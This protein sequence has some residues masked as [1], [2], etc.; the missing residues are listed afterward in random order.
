FRTQDTLRLEVAL[1]GGRERYAWLD[2]RKF[3]DRELRDLVGRGMTGTGNFALHTQH[4]F[5]PGIA[6]FHRRGAASHQGRSAL[7]YDYEVPWEN[8]AYRISNPPHEEVVAFRGSFLVDAETLDLLR[9]EVLAAEI[10]PELGF[11]R[12]SSVLEYA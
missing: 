7:R 5:E 2:A 4:V 10:P 9:L 3:D 8:S 6:Q 1:I 11:D 12:V